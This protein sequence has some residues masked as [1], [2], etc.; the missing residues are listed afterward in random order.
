M[1]IFLFFVPL[2]NSLVQY[3]STCLSFCTNIIYNLALPIAHLTASSLK[4]KAISSPTTPSFRLNMDEK[5]FATQIQELTAAFER[6]SIREPTDDDHV[7]RYSQRL[8]T[9]FPH[10]L[11]LQRDCFTPW[12]TALPRTPNV[13]PTGTAGPSSINTQCRATAMIRGTKGLGGHRNV[14]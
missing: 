13:F 2:I 6:L 1:L 4:P 11:Y 3:Q 8:E 10:E 12:W 5:Q 14:Y 9:I 7:R